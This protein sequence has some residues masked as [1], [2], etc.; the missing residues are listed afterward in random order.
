[1][2]DLIPNDIKKKLESQCNKAAAKVGKTLKPVHL[3]EKAKKAIRDG[4]CKE[5]RNLDKHATELMVAAL[6]EI[7][8]KQK[9]KTN[10]LVPHPGAKMKPVLKEPGKGLPSL[11]IPVT[12]MVF[13][14]KNKVKGKVNIKIWGDPRELQ[15]KEKGGMLYFTVTF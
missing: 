15:K 9:P 1:M 12:D 10:E 4:I 13:D 2:G 3:D 8:K 14:K 5:A 11:T 6:K 7:L